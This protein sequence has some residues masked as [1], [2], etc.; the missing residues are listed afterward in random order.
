[1]QAF[2]RV[3]PPGPRGPLASLSGRNLVEL[4]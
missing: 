1:M 2:L 3:S 4:S